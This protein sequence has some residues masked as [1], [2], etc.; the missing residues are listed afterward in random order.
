VKR[1]IKAIMCC[2][3]ASNVTLD[4][5]LG[6]QLL[7]FHQQFLASAMALVIAAQGMAI[8]VLIRKA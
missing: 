7:Y 1:L 6:G 3:L 4:A 2:L 8:S 5:F